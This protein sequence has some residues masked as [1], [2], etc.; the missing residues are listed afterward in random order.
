MTFA[1]SSDACCS[2][3]GKTPPAEGP[4]DPR[5]TFTPAARIGPQNRPVQGALKAAGSSRP[6]SR[7]MYTRPSSALLGVPQT[8]SPGETKKLYTAPMASFTRDP[9]LLFQPWSR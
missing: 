2:R 1:T 4:V 3:T 8:G 5:A 6:W 7:A 9:R